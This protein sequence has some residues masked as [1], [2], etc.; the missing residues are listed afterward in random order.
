MESSSAKVE[1]DVNTSKN[2]FNNLESLFAKR[3]GVN[4]DIIEKDESNNVNKSSDEKPYQNKF[5]NLESLFAKRAGVNDDIREKGEPND[6]NKSSDEKTEN[7]FGKL[8]SL[9]AARSGKVTESG[10]SSSESS[11]PVSLAPNVN[12]S[13]NNSTSSSTDTKPKN[14]F[15]NLETLFAKRSGMSEADDKKS[16]TSKEDAPKKLPKA[17]ES[18]TKSKSTDVP[19]KDDPKF[20]KYFKMLKVGMPKEVVKH[21]MTRDGLD[22]E[23]IDGD[24][25]LPAKV[26]EEEKKVPLKEDPRFTKYFKM[27]KVGMPREAVKHAMAR[28]GLDPTIIDGDPDLP[29][30]IPDK[31]AKSKSAPKNKSR[32][33]TRL[34]WDTTREEVKSGSVWALVQ[35]DKDITID[36][37]E[38]KHLFEAKQNSNCQLETDG[39]MEGKGAKQNNGPKRR[40]NKMKQVSVKVIDQKR[41][42]NGGI[43][44]ARIKIS[45]DEIARVIDKMENSNLTQQQLQSILEY[46]PTSNEIKL[47]NDYV[48]GSVSDEE[49][50]QRID[51][52]CECEKFM[53]AM[54][55]VSDAEKKIR[56]L[57]FR[58][59]FD[60][61]FSELENDAILIDDACSE[62]SNSLRLRK[63]LGIVL[64]VGNRVNE[65]AATAFSITSLL[66]LNHAK[67]MD[68]RTT[69]LHYV[70]TVAKRN[71]ESLLYFKEDLP[72]VFKSEKVF[73]DYCLNGAKELEVQLHNV[74]KLVLNSSRMVDIEKC[75]FSTKEME[76]L[77]STYV[78]QFVLD[79]VLKINVL[80]QQIDTTNNSYTQL[81]EYFHEESIPSHEFF[82]VIVQFSRN[83][84]T[85]KADVD[86]DEIA[87]KRGKKSMIKPLSTLTVRSSK[88]SNCSK[89]SSE[90]D[91]S[92]QTEIQLKQ[93]ASL[94][95][96]SVLNELKSKAALTSSNCDKIEAGISE[97]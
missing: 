10:Q 81:L 35:E 6:V 50:T 32:R 7:K 68:K 88:S 54:I 48:K 16:T 34:H 33:R 76:I 18:E 59:Q 23:I 63:L 24:P 39:C 21:A 65:G 95:F 29:A 20:A 42:N 46:L 2:K 49:R 1:K 3:A 52:M 38:I 27:L 11:K 77:S 73:W 28:D 13:N 43:V 66:K 41:A 53:I 97:C 89:G 45:F 25:N 70:V 64:N 74:I 8:E 5:N 60:N 84:D 80:K 93:T 22:P 15:G 87:K 79:A 83:F 26:K 85:A 9:F 62:L 31:T 67:S 51:L 71:D 57:L 12:E 78:G 86:A 69:F 75:D 44:L 96:N 91:I 56:A 94:S 47:L 61:A 19:L 82:N 90:G 17:I 14:K 4:N 30:V 55:D 72:S 40:V 58:L 92:E 36:E 37:S